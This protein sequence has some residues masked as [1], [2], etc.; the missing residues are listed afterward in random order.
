[1]RERLRFVVEREGLKANIRGPMPA[2]ISRIQRL[3]RMQ[4]IVQT[5]E[6]KTMQRLFTHV[7]AAGP[8]RPA[9]KVAVDIDPV[10]LL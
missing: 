7:R 1:M 3:H 5:P 4:I 2:V 10:D 9:V 8:V 6:A